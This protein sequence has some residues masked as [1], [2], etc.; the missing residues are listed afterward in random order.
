[1][2]QEVLLVSLQ[3]EKLATLVN[4]LIENGYRVNRCLLLEGKIQESILTLKP[5]LVII[6][7]AEPEESILK[8]IRLIQDTMSVPI[9]VYADHSKEGLIG[10]AINAG[11]S[12]FVV[13]GIEKHRIRPIIEAATAR[14]NKCQ[15]MKVRL[16][17]TELKLIERKDIDRAKGILMNRKN[18]NEDEAYKS[19]RKM[20]MDNNQRLGELAKTLIIANELLN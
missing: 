3:T 17:E 16:T 19:L 4:N 7:I 20:A 18:I 12:G 14:F 15:V 6:Y 13:D 9:I 5:D 8:T 11:A 2:N 10:Q 1:M